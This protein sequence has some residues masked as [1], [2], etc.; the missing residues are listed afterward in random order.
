MYSKA[1]ID[2]M[3]GDTVFGP[4]PII[5][6]H[7]DFNENIPI[8]FTR[9]FDAYE[10]YGEL[11][12]IKRPSDDELAVDR[13]KILKLPSIL[14]INPPVTEDDLK[15][16]VIKRGPFASAPAYVALNAVD[17][18]PIY[19]EIKRK[20]RNRMP[21]LEIIVKDAPGKTDT[22]QININGKGYGRLGPYFHYDLK[23]FYLEQR[24]KDLRPKDKEILEESLEE[25]FGKHKGGR[26]RTH[27]RRK[28]KR[29]T[30]R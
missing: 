18:I 27:R 12:H 22:I 7:S 21:G 16:L 6:S 2:S 26:R 10:I 11:Y 1:D 19:I 9:Y 23:K 3:V 8:N 30:R 28:N 17:K 29:K 13:T 20:L 4:L 25:V 24:G 15:D 5:L 14:K